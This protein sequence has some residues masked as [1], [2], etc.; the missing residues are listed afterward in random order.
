MSAPSPSPSAKAYMSAGLPGPQTPW[1]EARYCVLDLETTGLDPRRDEIV[2]F[3]AVPV[4]DGRAVV[5]GVRQALVRPRRAMTAEA[6][7]IHGIRPQDLEDAPPLDAVLDD[8]LDAMA[9]R[10][11]VVHV[12]WVERGFLARPLRD[13]GAQ[14]REPVLDTARLAASRI[15]GVPGAVGLTWLA[16]ELGLPVYAEHEALGDALTTAQ[17]FVALAALM[18][19]DAPQTVGTLCRAGA[20]PPRRR[21]LRDLLG[22]GRR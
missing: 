9:G 20:A 16:R 15:P 18:D 2:S 6:V 5:R 1:R 22:R 11:L 7:T 4:D 8:L 14:L 12:D 21:R 17:V 13:R 10:V 3:A 19:R